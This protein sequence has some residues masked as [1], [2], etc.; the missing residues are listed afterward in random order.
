MSSVDTIYDDA[1]FACTSH[2]LHREGYVE[3]GEVDFIILPAGL[4]PDLLHGADGSH[5][6]PLGID[7][8][9]SLGD[10]TDQRRCAQFFC[11]LRAGHDECGSAVV[12]AWRVTGG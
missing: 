6:D 12:D 11:A 2:R 7:A 4:L 8:A 5:H 10:Y 3:F 9:G 1:K